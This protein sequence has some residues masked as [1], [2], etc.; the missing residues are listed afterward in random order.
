MRYYQKCSL[1]FYLLVSRSRRTAKD[2]RFLRFEKTSFRSPLLPSADKPMEVVA[3]SLAATWEVLPGSMSKLD[4]SEVDAR[5]L[6]VLVIVKNLSR[7]LF[8]SGRGV[9]LRSRI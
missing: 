1:S 4:S 2:T 5:S 8:C 3:G 7:R 9:P 6:F